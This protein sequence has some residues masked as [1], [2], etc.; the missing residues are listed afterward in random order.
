MTKY[1]DGND[2]QS[3]MSVEQKDYLY[4]TYFSCGILS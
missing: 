3:L 4:Q 2:I 1:P